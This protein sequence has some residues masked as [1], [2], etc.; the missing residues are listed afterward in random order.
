MFAHLGGHSAERC[1]MAKEHGRIIEDWVQEQLVPVEAKEWC[2][3]MGVIPGLGLG[4]ISVQS[5][6]PVSKVLYS[7]WG[8][9]NVPVRGMELHTSL[10]HD[11]AIKDLIELHEKADPFPD[12]PLEF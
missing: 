2:L 3:R 7:S 5:Y 11:E 4:S 8:M 9:V 1:L 10:A 12:R 6:H